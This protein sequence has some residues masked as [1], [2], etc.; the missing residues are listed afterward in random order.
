MRLDDGP[1]QIPRMT[2]SSTRRSAARALGAALAVVALLAPAVD[3][4]AV[5][6]GRVAE[7]GELPWVA[8]VLA[9]DDVVTCG[10]ALVAPKVVLTAAH[11]VTD[12]Q[13]GARTTSTA[14]R[15]VL[16]R[17]DLRGTGGEVIDV[18]GVVRHPLFSNRALLFDFALLELD[19]AASAPLLPVAAS[20]L[21][22]REGQGGTVAGWGLTSDGGRPSPVL[23]TARL[24]L[25]S[26]QRCARSYRRLHEPGLMLCAAA[27]RGGRDVCDGDSGG[28]LVTRDRAG[29]PK[30]LGV[31]SFGHAS[32][33]ASAR[34]PTNFA[35]AASPHARGWI[36]R[37]TAALDRGDRDATPPFVRSV[38]RAGGVVRYELSERAEVVLTLQRRRRGRLTSLATALVHRGEAGANAFRLSA[39][40]RRQ[41]RRGG[42]YLVRVVATD[43]AGN[44]SV[45]VRIRLRSA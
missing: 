14:R 27:R 6:G 26:N 7:P 4:H 2:G 37:R 44:L 33:C 11:C 9:D 19:R 36:V 34:Y 1:V 31:V 17:T 42:P 30:L 35:W 40:V 15:V 29:A 45:P 32:G 8:A 20:V 41:L 12:E 43:D 16:G 21:R 22:L 23:R 18:V 24:P 10:G 13:T 38:R 39:A 3:A 5:V 25:W 28:P